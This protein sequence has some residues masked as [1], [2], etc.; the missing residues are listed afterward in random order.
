MADVVYISP[1]E[2]ILI[3]E[4]VGG[5]TGCWVGHLCVHRDR[6]GPWLEERDRQRCS[7]KVGTEGLRGERLNLGDTG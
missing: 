7:G 4:V 2:G 5:V 3:A 1:R 6:E